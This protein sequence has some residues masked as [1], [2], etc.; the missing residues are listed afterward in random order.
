[1]SCVLRGPS[2][3]AARTAVPTLCGFISLLPP[4]TTHT[5]AFIFIRRIKGVPGTHYYTLKKAFWDF[6]IRVRPDL[7]WLTEVRTYLRRTRD[8][9]KK[10]TRRMIRI[11]R[12]LTTKPIVWSSKNSGG[13]EKFGVRVGY[14]S[15]SINIDPFRTAVSFWGQFVT[16]YLEFDCCVPKTG[17]EF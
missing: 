14:S 6:Y 16:K 5:I 12:P 3:V 17:L 10:K 9:K 8:G 2:G 11:G 4:D 13:N 7:I 15:T 1:M